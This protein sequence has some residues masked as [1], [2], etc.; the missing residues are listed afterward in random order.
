MFPFAPDSWILFNDNGSFNSGNTK[1]FNIGMVTDAVWSD[2]DGDGWE[3]LI[4]ARE[5]NSIMILQNIE[6]K[7]LKDKEIPEVEKV[8][9]I[10]FSVTA[11]DLDNDGDDDYILGNLGMNHR[12]NVSDTYPMQLYA[13]DIDNDGIIDPLRTAYWRDK[14]DVMREYPVNYL[15]ELTAQTPFFSKKYNDYTT[16]SY[17]TVDDML[18]SAIRKRVLYTFHV[19]NTASQILWN[20]N[21]KFRWEE[22]PVDVQVS[23]LKKVIVDDFND[24]N[25][26]DIIL[27]GNDYT[28][29]VATGYYDANKGLIMMSKGKAGKFEVLHPAQSGFF[30]QGM[31]ESLLYF[32]G[33]TALIVAGLN[34]AGVVVHEHIRAESALAGK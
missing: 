19:N 3:D 20:D 1:H 16:F 18:D 29:D 27:T 4:I 34:R 23:P 7:E 12:F 21:G 14:F 32:P 25:F 26:P 31:V 24:D 8:H 13:V 15:D 28:Y 9:G 33:D 10:W 22:L 2:F 30:L 5:W 17:A 11:A 6:G